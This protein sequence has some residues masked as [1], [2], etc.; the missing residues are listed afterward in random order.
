MFLWQ[1]TWIHFN[2]Y[3]IAFKISWIALEVQHTKPFSFPFLMSVLCNTRIRNIRI[4][5]T[6]WK[7]LRAGTGLRDSFTF[8]SHIYARSY[9]KTNP[10][11]EYL[12]IK[13]STEPG[14]QS[15]IK[16]ILEIM[17]LHLEIVFVIFLKR[18]CSL[19]KINIFLS[20]F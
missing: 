10:T 19:Y 2:F 1:Y 6:L 14:V 17:E 16:V 3:L 4:C 13:W 5:E 8:Y 12:S 20:W 15:F 11:L 9:E 7:E 18:I